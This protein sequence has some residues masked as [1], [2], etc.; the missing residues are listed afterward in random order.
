MYC[1]D[2]AEYASRTAWKSTPQD[3]TRRVAFAQRLFL[4]LVRSV[5]TTNGTTAAAPNA[6]AKSRPIMSRFIEH[7][8]RDEGREPLRVPEHGY[9]WLGESTVRGRSTGVRGCLEPA[10]P[11]TEEYRVEFFPP[12]DRGRGGRAVRW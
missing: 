9:P 7:N 4:R 10:G 11:V 2:T 5:E 3:R 6:E 8:L 1:P 12:N